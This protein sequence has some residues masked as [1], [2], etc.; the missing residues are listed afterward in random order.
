MTEEVT[1]SVTEPVDFGKPSNEI[2][3]PL[4]DDIEAEIEMEAGFTWHIDDWFKLSN[5]KYVSP[6]FKIGA[7]EWNIL[8]FPQSNH[9]KSLAV[10]I[11][12]H[13]EERKNSETGEMEYVNPDWYCCAQFTIILS[14]PEEDDKVH[15]INSSH[16]RFNA[17]D[18][19]W[20][21]ANFV[22]LN[23]LKYP[24]KGRPSGLLNK[25]MLNITA[26]VRILED[27]TGVL[28]H[29]F[30]NYDSKKITGYVGFR[31]QG[32]TCYL[33]SLLQSYF[34]TKYFRKLV[35]QIPTTNENPNDSVT[36]ALQRAF[37]Q[38]Q[39]SDFPLDTM[40]L[41][42][43]FGWDNAEAFTQHDIQELNRILMDRLETRMKGTS[44]EGKLNELFVGKMK[45]YIKCINVDY[46]S[47]RTEDFWDIQ[48]NVKNLK[49][50]QDS[51]EN[52]IEVELMDGENQYAAQDF[53]LQDA[54]KG[55]VFESFP[56][57]LH[58]QLKRFEYD[59]NYDQLIKVNDRYE[60]PESIDLSPYMDKD[61]LKETPGSRIYNLHGVLVHTGDISTGHYYALIKPGI[62]DQW[63]RF[64]DE[65]VWKV[66]KT[67]VF[68]QN[69]GCDRLPD[70]KLRKMTREQYQDYLITRHTNAYMLV[71]ILEGK[72]EEILQPVTE[73]DVPE[74]VVSSVL[75]ENKDRELREKDIREAH[76]Y[77][78]I[79]IN[80]LKNFLQYQ[81][82]DTSPNVRS[83]MYS[84]ELNST[85]AFSIPLKVPS[86]SYM[87]DIYK[88]INE[89]LG[90][91]HGKNV[92][93]WKMG[94]R[95]NG[96]IRLEEPMP[97]DIEEM[98]LEETFESENTGKVP[99]LDIFVEEPYLELGFLLKM[100][101][102]GVLK[103]PEITN[104]LIDNLRNNTSK[105]VPQDE[106]PRIQDNENRQLLFL[107]KFD[108]HEQ[109]LTGFGYC[110]V[111]QLDDISTL[112]DIVAEYLSASQPVEFYEELQPGSIELVPLK[113]KFYAA[114]LSSGDILTFQIPNSVL[115]DV[116]PVY[117]DINEFYQYLRHRIKLKFSKAQESSEEY[118]IENSCSEN[119][120]FWISSQASYSDIAR[121]V[122]RYTDV[123]PDYLK[124]FALYA[125][126]R[127][128]LKS[129]SSLSDYI[130]RDY[131]CDLKPLF[132]YE[133]LSLP[134][135]ELEHLRSMKF[136]WLKNSYIHYQ[137]YE[138]KV[139]NNCT[140]KEF[141]DKIQ[142]KIGF[143]D[144]DKSNILLWTN[145]NFQFQGILSENSTI[146]S[147]GKSV[148]LFGRI[149][150]EELALVKQLDGL[151]DH[152]DDESM[153]D[154]EEDLGLIENNA[155][156]ALQGRLVMV[157]QYFKE[158][159]NRHGISFLFKLIPEETFPK[160]RVRL[161]EKFGLGQKE[162]SKIKLGISF[163]T[164]GGTS[165]RSFQGYSEE[166]LD[167][168]VLY[169][170]M[171]NLDCIYM[172]HPD[173]LRS[174]SSHDRPMVI[175][176]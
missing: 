172:D 53:G 81:G 9:N 154:E 146:K 112:S 15:I 171:S 70:E 59:F 144:E 86:K 132:E 118:V 121:V 157:A 155:K 3:P 173:R 128:P 131:N 60:F 42:R 163:T 77:T 123:Q 130:V 108:P 43:S 117:K 48:L 22:D 27:K 159:E 93:Y 96:T 158:A 13:A 147:I 114:E 56:S 39:V 119:F 95:R 75:K 99:S 68:D 124:M 73:G 31:N 94:Y 145:Y 168:L 55:V 29:N 127:F 61:V 8:L 102:L 101:K 21:F 7:F 5:D 47:V 148:L 35:Y 165:F 66:T 20:G 103:S 151:A 166:E 84:P 64:D 91:P 34:F 80:S 26:Y 156:N 40:E 136:Y 69:F 134:L 62:E 32:A 38:L 122:S 36:L 18:T 104:D 74:H 152:D 67:Q 24:T 46:E 51:F 110:I 100:K 133:V 37:Y 150:P 85:E 72:E 17:T 137:S 78:S 52:Y 16:H 28:W 25:G 58:L 162:F 116:F 115:P 139:R 63:Y 126:G 92:R 2:L 1:G 120:E 167:K 4:D 170:V 169:N 140:V 83:S 88:K 82:F 33:N 138:F 76:L 164:P 54:R 87:K 107:K 98:T 129:D 125:N 57:V 105:L 44:V 71:Y 97:P 19:D 175:K 161:H 106:L 50:L 176:N 45:S 90:I 30:I 12:P 10:Y 174:Q 14:R 113:E 49:G 109:S 6:G 149:L 111:N 89:Q 143:S 142:A 141:L 153:D 65:K 11:E 160:T 23:H 79:R 135:K 41:T